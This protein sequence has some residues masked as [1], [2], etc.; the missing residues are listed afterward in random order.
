M[1]LAVNNGPYLC[2]YTNI[3]ILRK[4]TP[5]LL[6]MPKKGVVFNPLLLLIDVVY[7]QTW[8]V[9]TANQET[10]VPKR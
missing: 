2:G 6:K 7:A 10:R 3:L 4:V 9:I 1:I 5:I 8:H